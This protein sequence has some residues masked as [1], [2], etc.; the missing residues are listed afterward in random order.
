MNP[1]RFISAVFSYLTRKILPYQLHPGYVF[2]QIRYKLEN[3]TSRL[4][5]AAED[6]VLKKP[7][8]PKRPWWV[9]VLHVAAFVGVLCFLWWINVILDLDKVLRAPWPWLHQFWLP[10]LFLLGYALYW[11]GRWLW[12]LLAP[13]GD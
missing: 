12:A 11:L 7:T 10:L 6:A 5:H 1:F 3:W 4:E 8:V 13:I 9:Y 2:S